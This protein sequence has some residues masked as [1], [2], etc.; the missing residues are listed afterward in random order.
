ME[1]DCNDLNDMIEKIFTPTPNPPH[2]IQLEITNAS[3]SHAVFKTLGQL[4]TH[5]IVYLYGN[6]YKTTALDIDRLQQCM[7][8]IG[9]KFV[10]NPISP[11]QHPRALP[12][13][14]VIPIGMDN[15]RVIFEPLV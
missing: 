12:Y 9:W 6:D 2:S 8:S 3:D 11:E 10:L 7:A 15:V 1:I 14:L 13:Q 4:L 5:G